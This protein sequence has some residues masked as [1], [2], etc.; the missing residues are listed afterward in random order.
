MTFRKQENT[1]MVN[2]TKKSRA[3][4]GIPVDQITMVYPPVAISSP[5]Q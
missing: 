1:K 3:N 2:P 4:S 5:P